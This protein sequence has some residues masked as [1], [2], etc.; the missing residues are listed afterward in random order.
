MH[1]ALLSP[2]WS[3]KQNPNGIVTYVHW[4][5]EGLR[6]EGHRVSVFTAALDAPEDGVYLVQSSVL[7]RA[8][9]WLE[10]KLHGPRYF[11]LFRWGNACA[12]ALLR[13]HRR[14]PI[15]V[16]E[17][18]E[19]FG[20]VADVAR[21]TAVPTVVKLHGPAFMSLVDEEQGTLFGQVK[22]AQEGKALRRMAVITSPARRTLDETVERYAL[23]PAVSRH[24]VNPL[25]LP[26]SAPLWRLDACDRK[27]ILFVGRFDKRKGGDL[28]LQAFAQLL[29]R[30]PDLT[31]IF[32]GPDAGIA[33]EDGRTLHFDEYRRSLFP[34]DA[35]AR[36]DFRGKLAPDEI[37]GLRA[38]ALVTL[39]A[40]RWENQS[41]TA[42]EAMLQGCPVV[43]SSAGGQPEI[44]RDGVT[45]LLSEIGSAD[46]LARNVQSLL[47]HPERAAALGRNAREYALAQHAPASVV[48]ET[49][50]V[51]DAA[52][53]IAKRRR[54]P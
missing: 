47:D 49:L 15:D 18:E 1:V 23:A 5:R 20:W 6:Q 13:V 21:G 17:M 51:Y 52:I 7:H 30:D 12:N 26:P 24:I 44:V 29:E 8:R 40:S 4:M 45:G 50:E 35:A 36:V 14:D 28:V 34:A 37:Y 25:T 22:I 10:S 43:S 41:Y 38:R 33:T 3:P 9:G 32:V 53:S 31:L 39:I 16:I 11:P 2:A 46:D 48:R 19:S 27:T 42:L 54:T